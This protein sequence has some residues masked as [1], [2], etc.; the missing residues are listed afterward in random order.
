MTAIANH[1]HRVTSA[2]AAVR[3]ELASAT[4]VPVWSFDATET[5]T[6]LAEIGSAKAQLAELQ[7]R[8]L[9]HADRI[10]IA[11][12][13]AA[14]STAKWHAVATTTRLFTTR[15]LTVPYSLYSAHA[16]PEM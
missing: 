10:D 7:A 16:D 13:T 12:D 15:P 6:A 4:G 5:T 11:G 14:A 2:I 9:V 1:P 3:S 8:L